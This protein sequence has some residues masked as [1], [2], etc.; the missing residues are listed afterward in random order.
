MESLA[1]ADVV[2]MD[3]TGTLTRGRVTLADVHVLRDVPEARCRAVAASLEA[4]SEHPLA[5]ALGQQG[6]VPAEDVRVVPGEGIEGTVA[7][8]R[9]RVGTPAFVGAMSSTDRD[10]P[11]ASVVLGDT[12]GPLATFSFEDSPRPDAGSTLDALR[13]AGLEPEILSGDAEEPVRAL[14]RALDVARLGWR[15]SPQDKLDRIHQ[16]Q[17][18]G[19]RVVMVGDG[20]NDAPVLAGADVSVAMGAG[21]PLA[22]TTADMILLGESLAPLAVG[23]ATARKALSVIRQNIVWAVVYN[24]IA[25]PL[26]AAGLVAPWMA[27]IGMS[28]SSLLVVLN[29]TRLARPRGI[30]MA[31]GRDGAGESPALPATGAMR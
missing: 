31:S 17:R 10:D 13:S 7:G 21:A 25:L 30:A 22:Q 14:G 6:A 16:L 8:R 20:V 23:V 28:A 18:T 15:Q 3:K 12:G 11:G 2:V 29:S 19:H 24:L 5:A 4:A 27:A 1:N 26:A 9:Y